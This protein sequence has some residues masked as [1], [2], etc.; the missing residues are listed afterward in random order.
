M[1]TRTT[2]RYADTV[3]P[4]LA[5]AEEV[6]EFLGKIA[7][8]HRDGT[9][10]QSL[11]SDLTKEAGDILCQLTRVLDD[12]GISIQDCLDGNVS[13]L[14]DRKKRNVLLGSGDDR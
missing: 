6:G 7:K 14:E 9:S 11:M 3:Y 2:A 12:Y 1:W 10:P 4:Q 5:L 8:F 13:K